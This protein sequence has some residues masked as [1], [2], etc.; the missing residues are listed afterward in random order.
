MPPPNT[1]FANTG[2]RVTRGASAAPEH[3]NV[4]SS[5]R[6]MLAPRR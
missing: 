2:N 4:M 5:Q 3:A 1:C 6:G